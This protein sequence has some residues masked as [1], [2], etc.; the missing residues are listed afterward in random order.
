MNIKPVDVRH[1]GRYSVLAAIMLG[2]IMGPID[3]SIVNVILPTLTQFFGVHISTAQWVPIIYLLTISS[4]L[5]F[6]GRLGDILG[7]KRV[8][9]SGLASFIIAS[10]LCGLSPTIHWLILFRAIQGLAAGM[11]MAV[12]YAIITASFPPTERGKA[13]G[14]NAISISAGLAVGP[15]L[16]GFIT[17]LLGWR[18]AFLINIPIGIIGLLWARHVIPELKGQPGKMDILGTMTAFVSLFSFLLFVNRFQGSGLSYASGIMLLIAALAGISFLRAESKVRQPMLNL[19][20]FRNITF[21]FA[22]ISALLNFMSQYVMVFLTPFYLQRV[23]HYAPNHLGLIMTSFP[24]AVMAVAPFSGSLSDRIGTRALACSGAATCA[25]SLFFMSQVPAWASSVDVVW[26]LALFGL[27]TGIFQSPNISAVMGSA[28]KP[29]LGIASGILATMRN[30]GMVLGIT[31]AG[32]VLY[33]F[34]PSYILQKASLELSESALFLSGLKY[35]YLA[36]AILT[37]LASVTSL[38]RGKEERIEHG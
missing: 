19:S 16:G 32:A 25:L 3:A 38:I 6:Y 8:Y 35:A 4:L 24:L 33:A 15:S 21:S 23:L 29:H 30:V 36:G 7:Y 10:G 28:P 18:F 13:L 31:T 22:N 34:A 9:L 11:M 17:S 20:L 26:R 14:I 2:S 12:P 5:L 1:A 37:G 27:G